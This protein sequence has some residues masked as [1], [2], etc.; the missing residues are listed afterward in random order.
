MTRLFAIAIDVVWMP[1]ILFGLFVSS[2][3][4]E[5]FRWSDTVY[6]FIGGVAIGHACSRASSLV[7]ALT[8]K[9]FGARR[10][11]LAFVFAVSVAILWEIAE[12]FADRYWGTS[13]LG[14]WDDTVSDL[15]LGSAGAGL[16]LAA[17]ALIAYRRQKLDA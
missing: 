9:F 8:L 14:N 2:M 17:R 4:V 1:C 11:F 5:L 10:Y 15:V 12:F 3:F 13:L 16:L 6:H 7:P